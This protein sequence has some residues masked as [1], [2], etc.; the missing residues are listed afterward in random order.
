MADWTT[1]RL[2][3]VLG[4]SRADGTTPRKRDDA[5]GP[6]Y[7]FVLKTIRRAITRAASDLKRGR[8]R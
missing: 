7:H 8:T 5:T 4:P 3:R 1:T 2:N 6:A